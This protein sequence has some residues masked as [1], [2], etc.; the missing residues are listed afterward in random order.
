MKV[1]VKSLSR[2]RLLATP[3]TAAH[4]A[5]L[6]MD[7]PGKSPGV[8]C[9][10]L[11]RTVYTRRVIY[12]LGFSL[13]G[14]LSVLCFS[15]QLCKSKLAGQYKSLYIL[16]VFCRH[17]STVATRETTL[18]VRYVSSLNT[19]SLFFLFENMINVS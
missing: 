3:G 16:S 14:P 7:F 1:K 11:L 19:E 10:C 15:L 13:S 17:A 6:S 9:H 12:H 8:G 18:M 2:V 4:Q 5:P